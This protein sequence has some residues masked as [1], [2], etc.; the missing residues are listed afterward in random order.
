[1]HLNLSEDLDK[2][3]CSPSKLAAMGTTD[4]RVKQC[5]FLTHTN[6]SVSGS[7]AVEVKIL[8]ADNAWFTNKKGAY[9]PNQDAPRCV[10]CNYA[11]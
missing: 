7:K 3:S 4:I 8:G 2:L 9:H 6:F 5:L 1:M 11:K 10:P